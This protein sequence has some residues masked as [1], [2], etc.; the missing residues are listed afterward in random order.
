MHSFLD[1]QVLDLVRFIDC[2]EQSRPTWHRRAACRGAGTATFFPELGGDVRPAK[3][4]CHSC[5]VSAE[6]LAF[7]VETEAAGIWA[8]QSE[9]AWK[10]LRTGRSVAV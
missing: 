7:A 3:L 8:G 5:E 4:L 2:V 10:R 9:R 1:D 6:C